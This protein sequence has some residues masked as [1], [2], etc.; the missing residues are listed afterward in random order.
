MCMCIFSASFSPSTS[1]LLSKPSLLKMKQFLK[2]AVVFH[3]FSPFCVL[4]DL[5]PSIS[6]FWDKSSKLCQFGSQCVEVSVSMKCIFSLI[7]C[8]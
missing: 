8:I 1:L 6:I 7:A 5:D 4:K 2:Q 3:T